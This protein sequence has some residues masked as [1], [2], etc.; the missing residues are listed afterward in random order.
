M[1]PSKRSIRARDTISGMAAFITP[2]MIPDAVLDTWTVSQPGTSGWDGTRKCYCWGY[3]PAKVA[4]VAPMVFGLRGPKWTA[5]DGD[6]QWQ[7]PVWRICPDS[8]GACG[9]TCPTPKPCPKPVV[10]PAPKACAPCPTA[11]PCP[12]CTA[13]VPAAAAACPV[14]ATPAPPP[15]PPTASADGSHLAPIAGPEETWAAKWGVS[16]GWLL[17]AG[18]VG[19]GSYFMFKKGAFGKGKRR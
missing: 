16:L 7:Q 15:P 19:G 13:P 2:A 12:V 17:A 4:F 3:R 11:K 1:Q 10:C 9:P 5:P 18:A 14:C 8:K 6:N